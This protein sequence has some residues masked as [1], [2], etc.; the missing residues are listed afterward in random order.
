MM[1]FYFDLVFTQLVEVHDAQ[2]MKDVTSFK[3][4]VATLILAL[5]V[6]M[7]VVVMIVLCAKFEQLKDK[8]N[9]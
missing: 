8:K 7:P 4:I 2:E 3:V 9:K 6:I 1:T 5:T